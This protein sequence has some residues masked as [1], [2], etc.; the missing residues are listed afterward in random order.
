MEKNKSDGGLYFVIVPKIKIEKPTFT[1]TSTNQMKN[2]NKM[3]YRPPKLS[4]GKKLQNNHLGIVW[5]KSFTLKKYTEKSWRGIH[6][7]S[8]GHCL[9]LILRRA[10]DLPCSKRLSL[11]KF[12]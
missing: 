1:V 8:L 5:E 4:E 9:S 7:F 11:D 10:T 3:V 2:A 12:R 6:L